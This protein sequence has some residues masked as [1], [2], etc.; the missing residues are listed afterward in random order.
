MQTSAAVTFAQNINI[1]E[2][3][4][5]LEKV[6]KQ[7]R[8][9]SGYDFFYNQDLVRGININELSIKNASIEQAIQKTLSGLPL[10]FS[11]DNRIVVIRKL[12]RSPSAVVDSVISGTVY[13][14][15]TKDRLPGVNLKLKNSG[16]KT[17]TD[18]RGNFRITAVRGAILQVSYVGYESKEVTVT[19]TKLD[20]AL[21]ET[22]Q[23][24]S[25]VVVTGIFAQSKSTFTGAA[26]TFGAQ[27]LSKVS[28]N[29]VLTA[30][31]SLD[32]SFQ[33]PEN[34]NTGS[35]PNVLPDVVLRGGNTLVDIRQ[36][37]GRAHV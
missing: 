19:G 1:T 35:N 8:L 9:Q 23:S 7:I 24:L 37:I 22:A 10:T 17:V 3:N 26:K 2:K 15:K 21:N 16:A 6:L 33:L 36:K 31:K 11:V 28:N 29:N 20:I 12:D 13:D 32:P 30:L 5:P 18:A 34:L 27:E 14:A 4:V 25:G